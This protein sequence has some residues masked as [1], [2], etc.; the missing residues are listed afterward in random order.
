MGV[1]GEG[2][3]NALGHAQKDI[4][5]AMGVMRDSM[6]ML[7]ERDVKLHN[8][9]DK[10]NSLQGSSTAFTRQAKRL[11]WEQRWQQYRLVA[12]VSSLVVWAV[13]FFFLRHHA[14]EYLAA[15]TALFS[16]LFFAQRFLAKRW[17]AQLESED[18][19]GLLGDPPGRDG[20][21]GV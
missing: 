10:S 5:H 13:T 11:R 3:F 18:M 8:L 7:A 12:M 1:D 21:G 14:P 9:E 15:S 19:R 20:D 16:L 17:R 2:D 4:D 6:A